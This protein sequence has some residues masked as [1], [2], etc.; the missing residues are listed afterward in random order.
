MQEP[1]N[2]TPATEATAQS[3]PG[4]QIGDLI[5]TVQLISLVTQRG[6]VQAAE[7]SRVGAL[8]DRLV[9]FLEAN[10]AIKRAESTPTTEEN[11]Q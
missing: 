5:A 1:Q 10:G 8:Y 6:A 2:E 11:Q 3:G 9:A 4:L 7:M